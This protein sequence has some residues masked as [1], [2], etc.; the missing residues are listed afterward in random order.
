[1]CRQSARICATS[2]TYTCKTGLYTLQ[3]YVEFRHVYVADICYNNTLNFDMYTLQIYTA[4][5]CCICY[6][7]T[8]T[9]CTYMCPFS[10]RI[11]AK[12]MHIYV[13]IMSIYVANYHIYAQNL[14]RIRDD[15]YSRI[16]CQ[17]VRIW[18]FRSRIRDLPKA[19]SI[20]AKMV[21]IRYNNTLN[22]DMYTLQIYAA[23]IR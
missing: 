18:S 6:T 10:A 5:I 7:Y 17:T 13:H 23:T 15:T 8:F 3:Q 20:R 16:R 4:S 12:N 14:S 19:R 21:H 1:M 9:I 2:C 22:F 11:R